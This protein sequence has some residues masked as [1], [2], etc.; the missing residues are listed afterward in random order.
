MQLLLAVKLVGFVLGV[1][2]Q[3][4]LFVLIKRYRR[5]GRLERVLLVLVGCLFL[6]NLCNCLTLVFESL[7]LTPMT[8]FL[9]SVGVDPLAYL[10]LAL[11]PSLLLHVHLIFQADK[12]SKPMIPRHRIWEIGAYAPLIFLPGAFAEFL[13]AYPVRILAPLSYAKPFAAWFALVLIACV[14]IEW[15]LLRANDTPRERS[16]YR[17]SIAIF[18]TVAV[19]VFLAYWVFD[20]GSPERMDATVETVLL[21]WLNLPSGLLGYYIFRYRF[22]EVAIQRSLGFSL[23]GI[24]LLVIY[25]FVVRGLRDFLEDRI[26]IPGLLVEAAMILALFALAQPLKRWMESSV[27]QLFSLE[28]ARLSGMAARL[29]EVSRATVE[30]DR[31]VRFTENL[32]RSELGLREARLVLYP[33]SSPAGAVEGKRKGGR[34]DTGERFLLK[35]GEETI[36][37]LQ[38]ASASGRLSTEQ[39][40]GVQLVA[41]QFVGALQNCRLAQGKIE[42]ERELAERDKWASLGRLAAAVAHNVKNPLSSIKTI[43]Q[44]MQ[45]DGEVQGKYR[46]DL[47]LIN[48][49][50]DRLSHSVGQ[51]LKFSRPS[52]AG[53]S[54]LD[55]APVLDRIGQMF[56]AESERRRVRLI[57]KRS[58]Q[59]LPVQGN[60]EIFLEIFQN[61]VVNALEAAPAG[62]R[63]TFDSAILGADKDRRVRV[64]VEDEGPGIPAG[65]QSEM[66]RPFYT[67]KPGGTGLGLALAQRRVLDLGGEISCHSPV[68]KGG[69][70]RFEVAFPLIPSL[71]EEPTC[72]ES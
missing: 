33:E 44:L 18:L 68:S 8:T 21:L 48:G 41:A 58:S 19:L 5:I 38:A 60:E 49:E 2:L 69:G 29:E 20:H 59:P 3:V 15:R 32:L 40:A 24:L 61:L 46:S 9:L 55:L 16:L 50:I 1:A 65:D 43:V 13:Q 7:E 11:Q 6:W 66:F 52:V 4:S 35:Q 34:R 26:E 37:E 45:E 39:Q 56:Q 72:T 10:A 25:L 30:I 63:I 22:F 64:R 42:L 62:S 31:L 17:I 27:R 14:L 28:M 51:L 57:V 23:V 47:G 53:R 54:S 12:L 67:T 70:A 71:E 36:G